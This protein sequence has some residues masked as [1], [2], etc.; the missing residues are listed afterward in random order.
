MS[1][2]EDGMAVG[3]A[4]ARKKKSGGKETEVEWKYPDEFP[5]LPDAGKGEV[6]LLIRP[7]EERSRICLSMTTYSIMEHGVPEGYAVTIDWG[8]GDVLN[9]TEGFGYEEKIEHEYSSEHF[10]QYVFIRFSSPE[11]YMPY[12]GKTVRVISGLDGLGKTSAGYLTR[13]LA[14]CVGKRAVSYG[15]DYSF[16]PVY[17]RFLADDF[18]ETTMK[19]DLECDSENGFSGEYRSILRN[20]TGDGTKRIDFVNQPVYLGGHGSGNGYVLC[21]L[22]GLEKLT[23]LDGVYVNFF[24]NAYALRKLVLPEL[25]EIP[26]NFLSYNNSIEEI[27]LPKCT[28]VGASALSGNKSLRK[29]VLPVN[30]EIDSTAFAKNPNYVEIVYV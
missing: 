10:G 9:K 8:D 23:S 29:V 13:V 22:T 15:G 19:R 25:T 12:Y 5:P 21:T 2:F 24:R 27:Y 28:K 6:I 1:N 30:C 14:A 3:L 7:W 17:V 16:N 26:E 4:I 11:V 20:F 18:T